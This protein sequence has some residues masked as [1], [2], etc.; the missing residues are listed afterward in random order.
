MATARKTAATRTAAT[1]AP[2]VKKPRRIKAVEPEA[3]NPVPTQADEPLQNDA[4][5][6]GEQAAQ[7]ADPKFDPTTVDVIDL[8]GVPAL[9]RVHVFIML[10]K[11]GY[12]PGYNV[13]ST[14]SDQ[15]HI[16]L[17]E[18]A[19]ELQHKN[20]LVFPKTW[21]NVCEHARITTVNH[22]H[23]KTKLDFSEPGML[24]PANISV[25]GQVYKAV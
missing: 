13:H 17:G 23:A 24:P 15:L 12:I 5:Q 10:E 20:K 11:E 19:I 18:E 6:L 9:A 14:L 22:F 1:A 25:G 3:I 2:A 21:S 16:L 8:R 7:Q 4:G